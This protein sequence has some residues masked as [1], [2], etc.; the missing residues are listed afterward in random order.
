MYRTLKQQWLRLLNEA[1]SLLASCTPSAMSTSE[2]SLPETFYR[3]EKDIVRTDRTHPFFAG[4]DTSSSITDPRSRLEICGN[5]N[6]AMMRDV[7]MT[8][9]CGIGNNINIKNPNNVDNVHNHNGT[10]SWNQGY[11]QGMTDLCAPLAIVFGKDMG[12]EEDVY[13]A[14]CGLMSRMVNLWLY[15]ILFLFSFFILFFLLCSVK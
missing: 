11:V 3:I 14:F 7:V 5:P 4:L 10:T 12:T 2:D 6:L 1:E 13:A 9:S 8:W 15:D